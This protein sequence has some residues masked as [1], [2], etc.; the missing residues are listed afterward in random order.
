MFKDNATPF[1]A[2]FI[3]FVLS[4]YSRCVSICSGFAFQSFAACTP[5][6]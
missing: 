2:T 1:Y 5:M 6:Q 3:Q 4:A